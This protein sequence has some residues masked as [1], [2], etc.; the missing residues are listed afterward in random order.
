MSGTLR[1]Q[2]ATFL[3]AQ[4]GDPAALNELLVQCR[5][6][7][8]RYA[9]FQCQRTSA[10]EDI[11]QEA[12]IIVYRRIGT[13][14]SPAALSAWLARIVGRLCLLPALMY[15]K[16]V[17]AIEGFADSAQLAAVPVD[18][19]RIDLVRAL[20]SLPPTHRDIILLR[21]MQE[22]T[23]AEIAERLNLSTAAAKSRLH[24]AR[25]LVR[26]YLLAKDPA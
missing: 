22:L 16:G 19:L 11:V 23:I 17:E 6:N 4:G 9:R 8:H 5:P 3:A 12:L 14:Q 7:I 24:R 10:V 2:E 21:D 20:E 1:I 18:E 13:V 15:M 25:A 26:E